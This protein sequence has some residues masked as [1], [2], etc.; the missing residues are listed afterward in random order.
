MAVHARGRYIHAL[1]AMVDRVAFFFPL[2][3]GRLVWSSFFIEIHVQTSSRY[4]CTT[5]RNQV[6]DEYVELARTLMEKAE[7]KGVKF[8]LP[9]DVIIADKVCK[10]IYA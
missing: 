3:F 2:S 8:L 4:V 10:Y 6:E 5:P 9:E 1:H 7:A